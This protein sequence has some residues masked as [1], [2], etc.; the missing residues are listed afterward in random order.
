MTQVKVDH[1]ICVEP[2]P[3][4]P[5]YTVVVFVEFVIAQLV[6]HEEKDQDA[7]GHPDGQTRHIDQAVAQVLFDIPECD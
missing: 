7:A 1:T 5:V 2:F 6:E 4:D 3:C